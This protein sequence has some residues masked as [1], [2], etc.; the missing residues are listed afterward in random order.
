M[1]KSHIILCGGK[2][3]YMLKKIILYI[4]QL[5]QNLA[6]LALLAYNHKSIEKCYF[7]DI[8]YW[9]AK[10]IND[11]GISLGNYIFLDSDAKITETKIKHEHGH[12]IQ[13]KYFGPLY[14]IVIGLPSAIGNIIDRKF[15][16]DWDKRTK[17][18]WY[19]SQKWEASADKL[20]G[21]ERTY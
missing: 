10:H 13:S 2:N 18:F 5:P 17:S 16:K 21:V 8:A 4:W 1:V 11:C 9:K 3:K 12:Q 20:G 15:H 19:Y 14:L 6:G 7:D